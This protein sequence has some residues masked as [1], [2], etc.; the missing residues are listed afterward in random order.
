[1]YHP[2][3]SDQYGD[4]LWWSKTFTADKWHHVKARYKMNSITN[5][6]GNNDGILQVWLDGTLVV[7]R[8][9]FLFRNKSDVHVSHLY[10]HMFYGGATT[11][12]AAKVPTDIDT[13]N[14]KVTGR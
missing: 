8:S 13:D 5:G 7:N 1:M 14:L 9:N 4:N 3:Q 12:W 6:V 11:A 10:W 2:G